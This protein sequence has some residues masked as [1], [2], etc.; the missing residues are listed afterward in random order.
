LHP[1]FSVDDAWQKRFDVNL[2]R[3]CINKEELMSSELLEMLTKEIVDRETKKA[4]EKASKKTEQLFVKVQNSSLSIPDIAKTVGVSE[5]EVRVA[6]AKCM[7]ESKK[8]T[9][10]IV[11]VTG[12]SAAKIKNIHIEMLLDAGTSPEEIAKITKASLKK[13]AKMQ[14]NLKDQD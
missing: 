10:E 3:S 8:T 7:L 14:T 2:V 6:K 13:I 12:L 5:D 9:P 11:S 4:S 1:S